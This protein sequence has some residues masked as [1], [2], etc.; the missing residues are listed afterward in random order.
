MF[1]IT[2][3]ELKTLRKNWDVVRENKDKMASAHYDKLFEIAPNVE[4]LFKASAEVQGERLIHSITEVLRL[5]DVNEESVITYIKRLGIKHRGFKVKKSYYPYMI[6][7]LIWAISS[8][9]GHELTD[10]ETATW[11]KFIGEFSQI[12]IAANKRNF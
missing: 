2:P 1:T 12:M 7:S 5:L 6:D 8:A 11:T 9:L 10:E 3:K 4:P